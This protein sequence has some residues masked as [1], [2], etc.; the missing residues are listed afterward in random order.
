VT[1]GAVNTPT[2]VKTS[3]FPL[4]GTVPASW[5]ITLANTL[6]TENILAE[7]R[8]GIVDAQTMGSSLVIY[9]AQEAWLMTPDTS[10]Q[11]FSY[12]KLPFNKG[13]INANCSVEIDGKHYVFGND[14]C[15]MHDGYSEQ[16]ICDKKT[17][18][19]IFNGINASKASH[20]FVK[21][22]QKLQQIHF[23]YLSGDG[24]THFLNSPE[25]C[26]RAAVYDYSN[27]TWAFDDLPMVHFADSVNLSVTLTYA[28]AT[29]TYAVIGGS[30][31]DQEDGFKRTLAYVGAVSTTYS[32]A[33]SLY[34]FDLF[35]AG[36]TVVFGVDANATAPVVI[37]K[38][39]IDLDD[40]GKDLRGY[41]TISS[42]YPQARVDPNATMPMTIW[43]GS[44]DY[45]GRAPIYDQSQIYD[46]DL[47]YKLDYQTS[48]RFLAMKMTYPD[49]HPFTMTGF[50]FEFD[51]YGER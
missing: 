17:R 50:D 29:E 15:W 26:N 48:G 20:C 3:S 13:A 49:Y 37:E 8:G 2:M 4:S 44:N 31:L 12:R 47:L 30:Y 14:D 19:F 18:D 39:G 41:A 21:V 27:G 23:C 35:G 46:G 43:M 5:D 36:S 6:A 16:S 24:Y 51:V 22:N 45:F 25:G 38:T 10:T 42:I 32:L 9:G 7:M 28:T 11:V 40:L 34:A 1:K 33:A